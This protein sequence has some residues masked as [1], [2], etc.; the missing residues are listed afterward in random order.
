LFAADEKLRQAGQ[1]FKGARSQSSVRA[2]KWAEGFV[3]VD[4]GF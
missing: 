1:P 4:Y 2:M 3:E